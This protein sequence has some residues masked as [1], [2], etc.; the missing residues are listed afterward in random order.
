MVADDP[1]CTN[2]AL[3]CQ[4]IKKGPVNSQLIKL[5]Q[6]GARTESLE[7]I[8]LAPFPDQPDFA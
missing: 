7:A 5:N 6:I 4:A 2:P 8:R 1:V 3:I